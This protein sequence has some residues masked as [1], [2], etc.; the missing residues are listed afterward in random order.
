MR[1]IK[2][3]EKDKKICHLTQPLSFWK[4]QDLMFTPNY[5]QNATK[6]SQFVLSLEAKSEP[7]QQF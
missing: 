6:P 4:L 3:K 1:R 2:K 5:A 7:A